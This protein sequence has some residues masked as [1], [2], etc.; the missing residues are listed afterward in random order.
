MPREHTKAVIPRERTEAARLCASS[1][2]LFRILRSTA[3]NM[4]N[5]HIENSAKTIA[6]RL[7]RRGCDSREIADLCGF[8]TRTLRQTVVRYQTTGSVAKAAAVGWGVGGR[9]D[10]EEQRGRRAQT[11]GLVWFL[12]KCATNALHP[13][14][15]PENLVRCAQLNQYWR[16]GFGRS[17]VK[18]HCQ[19]VRL[20]LPTSDRK[21]SDPIVRGVP[22]LQD[23]LNADSTLDSSINEDS[24]FNLLDP[25]GIKDLEAMEEGEDD[26]DTAAPPLV[27]RRA[28]LPTMDI[29]AYVDLNAPALAARFTPD[30][31]NSMPAESLPTAAKRTG[32]MT[33][34]TDEDTE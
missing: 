29:E 8:S 25:Y 5:R 15:G 11:R 27:I 1:S 3:S 2:S 22:T 4:G 20:K 32:M 26:I 34:W 16:Y 10:V 31:G 30:Q 18:Q 14:L 9:E 13:N 7:L 19:K 21:P 12:V 28:G 24:L 6:L 23:I 33:K 17:E